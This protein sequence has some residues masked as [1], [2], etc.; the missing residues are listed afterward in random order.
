MKSLGIGTRPGVETPVPLSCMGRDPSFSLTASTGTSSMT[1]AS[2]AVKAGSSFIMVYP[3]PSLLKIARL[4]TNDS[5]D[6]NAVRGSAC[7]AGQRM[8]SAS[9]SAPKHT[10]CSTRDPWV[11]DD[12]PNGPCVQ[13]ITLSY[14]S[15]MRLSITQTQITTQP[16]INMTGMMIDPIAASMSSMLH[17][18]QPM[19]F[20]HYRATGWA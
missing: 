3:I 13:G 14:I 2:L 9:Q 7:L 8:S 6:I 11:R 5:C 12:E 4:F 19:T 1:T 18:S 10:G 17:P 16:A 15:H 20:K